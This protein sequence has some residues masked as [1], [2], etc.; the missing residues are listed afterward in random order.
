MCKQ[1]IV[2]LAKKNSPYH[3]G[4]APSSVERSCVVFSGS[5]QW[6]IG[7][8]FKG[9]PVVAT[10]EFRNAIG[11]LTLRRPPRLEGEGRGWEGVGRRGRRGVAGRKTPRKGDGT[12][13][14]GASK[15]SGRR[16]EA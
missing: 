8:S 2:F 6:P 11:I 1:E 10:Q 9:F 13:K 15:L 3:D 12:P 16:E 4:L 7:R 14:T 5:A